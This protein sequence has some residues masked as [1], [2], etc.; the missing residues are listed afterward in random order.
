MGG[1]PA[2]G[3]EQVHP[4]GLAVPAIGQVQREETTCCSRRMIAF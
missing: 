4:V 2:G 3:F 1:R